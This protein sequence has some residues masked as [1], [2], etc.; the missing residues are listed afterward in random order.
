M[1]NWKKKYKSADYEYMI[2]D[3]CQDLT[4]MHLM[5]MDYSHGYIIRDCY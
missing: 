2:R 4:Y 3:V 1:Q 5:D